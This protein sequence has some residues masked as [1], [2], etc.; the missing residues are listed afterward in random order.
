MTI[1]HTAR[2]RLEPICAAQKRILLQ[3]VQLHLMVPAA[4]SMSASN[5]TFP[6]WQLPW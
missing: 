5:R 6:Q 2:L 4:R 1:L 3:I